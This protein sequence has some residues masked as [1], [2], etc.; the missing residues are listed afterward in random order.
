LTAPSET[1]PRRLRPSRSE[2]VRK[3][4]EFDRIQKGGRRVNTNHFVL[5]LAPGPARDQ[6]ARLGITASRRI[7][8]AVQRNRAKRLIRAAFCV[9]RE[10]WLPGVDLVVIV[11][12]PLG[13]LKL[14]EVVREW[15][16]ALPIIKKRVKEAATA[17][18]ERQ[19]EEQ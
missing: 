14:E 9:T 2:R 13:E 15:E 11:K 1:S 16:G 19:R 8:G 18:A 5:V 3:R 12:K 4:S 6:A 10:V 17:C 7:G